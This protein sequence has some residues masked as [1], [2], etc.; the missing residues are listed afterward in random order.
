MF[1]AVSL[2]PEIRDTLEK[3]MRRLRLCCE[4]GRFVQAENLHLTIAFLGEIPPEK[5]GE[6]RGAMDSVGAA[7]FFLHVGGFGY[8][9]R[10]DGNIFWAGVERSEHLT[11]LYRQ[12]YEQ[13]QNRGFR[14]EKRAF[15]PHLTLARQAVLKKDYDHGAFV[16]PAKKMRVEKITLY[17]SERPGGILKYTPVYEKTLREEAMI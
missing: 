10:E 2:S 17:Q 9:R 13:L 8:F 12:L 14:L 4:S 6:V 1:I 3:V 5:L 7:P 15:R 16:V 11:G